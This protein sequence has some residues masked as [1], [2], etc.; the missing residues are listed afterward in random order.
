MLSGVPQGS[1]LGPILFVIFINDIGLHSLHVDNLF[2][3]ADDAKCFALIK[4]L[5]D[6]EKFQQSLSYIA[7]WS[8]IWQ[9]DL[10]ADKCSVISYTGHS[11]AIIFDYSINNI[12]L[13]RVNNGE[14]LG[15]TFSSDL[16]FISHIDDMCKEGRSKS[17]ILFNCFKTNNRDILLKAFVT[18]ARPILEYCSNL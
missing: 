12:G 13:V 6:C 2:L 14:V 7:E 1:V 16:T 8:L 3:F 9:L 15:I 11:P 5:L 10:A 18:F 17:A 4:S